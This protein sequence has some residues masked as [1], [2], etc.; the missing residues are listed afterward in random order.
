MEIIGVIGGLLLVSQTEKADLRCWTFLPGQ[1]HAGIAKVPPG[2]HRVRIEYLRGGRVLYSTP[3]RS[4]NVPAASAGMAS[5]V[6]CEYS[7]LRRIELDHE[8]SLEATPHI[9]RLGVAATIRPPTCAAP[10]ANGSPIRHRPRSDPPSLESDAV[11]RYSRS[12]LH[13]VSNK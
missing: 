8:A 1:A 4:V 7:P 9:P 10:T 11:A 5:R 12:R 2:E 3:P 13:R 6:E